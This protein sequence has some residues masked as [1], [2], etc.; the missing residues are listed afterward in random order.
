MLGGYGSC[1]KYGKYFDDLW[2]YNIIDNQWTKIAAGGNRPQGRSN[3]SLHFNE[4][5]S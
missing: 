4:A 5:T 3:Y 1:S 2:T